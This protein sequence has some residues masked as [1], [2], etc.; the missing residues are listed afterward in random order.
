M[1]NRDHTPVPSSWTQ[2]SRV[3]DTLFIDGEIQDIQWSQLESGEYKG[4]RRVVLNSFGGLVNGALELAR[5]IRQNN[6]D[7]VVPAGGVC[8][9]ACTLVFQA[10]INR[11]AHWSSVFMYHPP[12]SSRVGMVNFNDYCEE[13]GEQAC[14]Q[15]EQEYL[16]SARDTAE[17][18][19]AHYEALGADPGLTTLLM[20]MPE[21]PEEAWREDGNWF[22]K[23]DLVF[24]ADPDAEVI[25][26]R[27]MEPAIFPLHVLK[28]FHVVTEFF[29]AD[30]GW[31]VDPTHDSGAGVGFP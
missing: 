2:E 28:Q 30:P 3:G 16:G 29:G 15:R 19:Y 22:K 13:N 4:V 17:K 24:A 31:E 6:I 21:E 14:K 23:V 1:T 20:N 11:Q 5:V 27:L 25:D 8:M 9:S 12:R 18:F 26:E 10:G 7:T